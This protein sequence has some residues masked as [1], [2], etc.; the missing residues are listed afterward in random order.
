MK[1][2]LDNF[3]RFLLDIFFPNRCPFCGKFIVW[4]EFICGECEES[5]P[6]ANGVICRKCGKRGCVCGESQ[7]Y[8][9]AFA[10]F[11]FKEGPVRDAVYRFKHTGESNIAEY[12]AKDIAFCMKK[13]NIPK[14]D[15]VIPVPMGRMKQMKRGH[16]Q[17]EILARC[18]GKHLDI[19]VDSRI[20]FKHDSKGE[21]HYYGKEIRRQRAE[22]LFYSQNADLTGMTVILCDDV[23]TTGATNRKC[24]RLLKKLG[25]EKVISA[26]CAVREL[27]SIEEGA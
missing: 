15:I 18:I 23:M 8:D 10:A 16:N 26:V 1:K 7:D 6:K 4:N 27:E 2:R 17:A 11:F 13:E 24:A 3:G 21:Q 14:P 9:M 20:L 25:A 22:E 19:P 12:T 5:V